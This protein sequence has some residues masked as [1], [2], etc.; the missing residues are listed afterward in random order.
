[1]W[2]KKQLPKNLNL[3]ELEQLNAYVGHFNSDLNLV[4]QY[5]NAV[6]IL[7][8]TIVES[9]RRVDMIA[10][11]LLYL[12]RHSVELSLKENI[13]YLQTYSYLSV[14]KKIM[15]SHSLGDLFSEFERHYNKIGIDLNFKEELSEGYEKY[16]KDLRSLIENLGNDWSSFRYVRSTSD[17]KIFS[18]N[19]ILN[20]YDLKEKYDN[21]RVLL[22]HT[23]DAISPFT[24]FVDYLKEDDTIRENSLGFVLFS[25]PTHQESVIIEALNRDYE[26][27]SEN[28]VWYDKQEK[29]FIY[30]KEANNNYYA[31]PMRSATK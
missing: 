22:T 28:E 27:I 14:G 15:K 16:A 29:H 2:F 11:P 30:L 25:L 21:S 12:M 3:I 31:I 23:A 18:H 6:D 4:G 20:V 8:N 24:D 17:E 10:H 5:E 19:D 13:K 9:N 1:M 7:I 26:L